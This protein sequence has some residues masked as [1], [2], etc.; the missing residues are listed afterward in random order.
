M[1]IY[2][3]NLDKIV[4]TGEVITAK[5]DTSANQTRQQTMD[6]TYAINQCSTGR[7]LVEESNRYTG[8]TITSVSFDSMESALQCIGEATPNQHGRSLRSSIG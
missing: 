4:L 1:P 6:K 2:L 7:W 8:A 3:V 5:I